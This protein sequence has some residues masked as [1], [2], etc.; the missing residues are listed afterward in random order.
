MSSYVRLFS[1]NGSNK[2][3]LADILFVGSFSSILYI[4]LIIVGSIFFIYNGVKSIL[5]CLFNFN[6]KLNPTPGNRSL[7]VNL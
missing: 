5:H 7:P 2:H 1:K 6:T 3:A 4:K